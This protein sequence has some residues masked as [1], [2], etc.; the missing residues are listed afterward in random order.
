M[1]DSVPGNSGSQLSDLGV[2]ACE[3]AVYDEEAGV[4]ESTN[5]YCEVGVGK[6]IQE[7]IER[8]LVEL[9]VFSLFDLL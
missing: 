9:I 8:L 5:L 4:S 6:R 1:R 2:L 3:D 7:F